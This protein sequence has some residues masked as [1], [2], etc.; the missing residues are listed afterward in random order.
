MF[1]HQ[2]ALWIWCGATTVVVEELTL[3]LRFQSGIAAADFNRSAPLVLQIHHL[4]WSLPLFV[5]ADLLRRWQRVKAALI[6]VGL[7][8]IISDL[9]HHFIFLPLLVGNTGWHWP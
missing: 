4:F 7:G 6:G 2:R 1:R 9:A 8:L 3:W 5:I